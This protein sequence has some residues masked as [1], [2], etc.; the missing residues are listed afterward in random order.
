VFQF[1]NVLSL[2]DSMRMMAVN[3]RYRKY[4]PGQSVSG[5]VAAWWKY[6]YT[7]IVEET[8]RPFSWDRIKKVR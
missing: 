8:I 5:H 3:Q 2:T 7:A 1:L 4:S 6:A